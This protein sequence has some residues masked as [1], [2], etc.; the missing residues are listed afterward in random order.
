MRVDRVV[1]NR[2]TGKGKGFSVSRLDFGLQNAVCERVADAYLHTSFR[3]QQIT[4]V[5]RKY[6][7]HSHF[8]LMKEI[9]YRITKVTVLALLLDTNTKIRNLQPLTH[10]VKKKLNV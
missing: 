5:E 1:E 8:E 4:P 2:G 10:F 7:G 3:H 6:L 9:Y